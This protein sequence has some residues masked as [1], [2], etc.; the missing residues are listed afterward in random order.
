MCRYNKFLNLEF[1]FIVD[2]GSDL[3]VITRYI[4]YGNSKSQVPTYVF[5]YALN[6]IVC[7]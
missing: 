6:I 2:L 5:I 4:T 3:V 7:T 1:I